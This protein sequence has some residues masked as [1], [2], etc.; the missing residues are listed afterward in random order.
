LSRRAQFGR[1]R[2][3]VAGPDDP[4]CSAAASIPWR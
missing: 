3:P 4:P 2:R 1:T